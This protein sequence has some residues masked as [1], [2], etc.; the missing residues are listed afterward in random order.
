MESKYR[1]GV[2]TKN[3]WWSLYIEEIAGPELTD[4]IYTDPTCVVNEAS[5]TTDHHNETTREERAE[6]STA[7]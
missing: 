7:S 2:N 1:E 6:N 4:A 5:T 3:P